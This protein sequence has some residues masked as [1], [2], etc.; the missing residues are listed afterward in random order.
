MTTKLTKTEMEIMRKALKIEEEPV[1]I[2]EPK[3]KKKKRRLTTSKRALLIGFLMSIA[4]I[5][6]AAWMVCTHRDTAT[7]S[8]F[9]GAGVAVIPLMFGIYSHHSTQEKLVHMEHAYDPNYNEN[10][11]L[12]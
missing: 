8:I 2:E 3:V 12:K 5:L 11:G 9:A 6:F 1:K 4:L 7:V 10:H